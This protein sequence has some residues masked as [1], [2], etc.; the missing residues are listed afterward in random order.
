MLSDW[1][2]EGCQHGRLRARRRLVAANRHPG[3]GCLL[4]RRRR[5]RLPLRPL[6]GRIHRRLRHGPCFFRRRRR[7]LVVIPP[8]G[9]W[10]TRTCRRPAVPR[11]WP[12]VS[13]ASSSSSSVDSGVAGRGFPSERAILHALSCFA[14]RFLFLSAFA[15]A[16]SFRLFNF[17]ACRRL[18]WRSS[19][20][21]GFEGCH[22]NPCKARPS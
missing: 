15:S 17:S 8:I 1:A 10:G 16:A 13:E 14:F 5:G 4:P 18:I 20:T 3:R 7:P 12:S 6:E 2:H 11:R 21:G 9:R 19:G 22:F